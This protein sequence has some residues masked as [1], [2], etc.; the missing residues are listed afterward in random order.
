MKQTFA[1][2]KNRLGEISDLTKIGFLLNWDQS[3]MMPA[4]G[5]SARA[6]QIATV[7]RLSH[8]L[9]T[10][11]EV[12]SLLDRLAGYEASLAADSD[13][14]SLIRVVR[15]DWE[16]A[17]KIPNEL[18]G[19]ISKA[20]AAGYQ[21]WVAARKANDFASFLP[22]L[23]RNLE[24]KR[25]YIACF[26]GVAEPYDAL[27]DDFER[28]LTAAEIRPVFARVR[29]GI[30]HLVKRV[31][32]RA[33]AVDQ[34]PMRGDF[35]AAKQRELSERVIANWGY[36]PGEWR[37][38]PTAHPFATSIALN[39]IRLTTRYD[40][41]YLAMSFFGTMHETGHGLYE[42]GVSP[43]L[44][45]TPLS[46][47]ASHALHESQSRMI[48]NLV[49][50]SRPFWRF[51][52]PIARDVFPDH[53]AKYDEEAVYRAVNKMGPSLI[54]VEADELTYGLHIILR[55]EIEQALFNGGLHAKELPEVWNA[56]VNE[57]LGIDVPNDAN[58]V[59]Q[60]VH[61]S[62]GLLGYFPTYALG[63]IIASQIWERIRAEIVD[64]DDRIAAGD[65]DPLRRW[66]VE[67]LHHYGR[68]F[69]PKET[70]AR[71][72]GG[73]INPEPYLAYLEGKVTALYGSDIR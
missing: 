10:S 35:P 11:D 40:E 16:K 45:R 30:V 51:A 64:L 47:G 44:A 12:G 43:T 60:D 55:F 37:L 24:L 72:A 19:E 31:T 39:D 17:R 5:G 21:A 2:L 38:D 69:T 13:K 66:L 14:A 49:G 73:P 28:G 62:E 26:P 53:F 70:L 50:R 46:R 71:V 18:A 33:N 25:R 42:H 41:R 3:T 34:S 48:E 54:R 59:L 56:K 58:G 57:Y 8:R 27:I 22:F 20:S 9:F 68:K 52:Y 6:E 1:E 32:E 63:T 65:F 4:G 23:E 67:H 15:G 36:N 29:D 61:W 7:S